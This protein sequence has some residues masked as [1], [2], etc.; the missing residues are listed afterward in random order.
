M[1]GQDV[2][3]ALRGQ[4]TARTVGERPGVLQDPAPQLVAE[5]AG[6]PCSCLPSLATPSLADA[7]ADVLDSSSL[8]FLGASALAARRKEEE[9][10]RRMQEEQEEL[11]S[12]SAMER[13]TPQQ[14]RRLADLC[15]LRAKRKR[16]KK[17]KR[18]TPRTSSLSLR[19]RARRRPRQWPALFAG[20]AGDVPFRAAFPS[21]VAW[22]ATLGIIAGMD[23]KDSPRVWCALRR[24]WQWHVPSLFFFLAQ[25][26]LWLQTGPDARHGPSPRPFVSGSLLFYLVLA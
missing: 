17:R 5:H 14:N 9:E 11:R 21:V 20:F 6:C 13:R 7:T 2:Y 10:E 1:A 26:S 24:L 19:G 25:C 16:K 18:R 12:L 4:R 8:S 3:E 23:L 22:P 15:L